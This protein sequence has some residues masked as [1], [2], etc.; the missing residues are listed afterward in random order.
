MAGSYT[1]QEIADA[2]HL[3]ALA[4]RSGAE[5][6][7]IDHE[8]ANN[9]TPERR[10]ELR[11]EADDILT[12][13]GRTLAETPLRSALVESLVADARLDANGECRRRIELRFEALQD[14]KRRLTEA[15]LRL[16]V[17]FAKRYR[18]STMS[19]L[20]RIQEGNLGL[21]KAVD[22]FQYRRGFKFSTYAV[23]WIRQS[24]SRAIAGSGGPSGYPCTR[25]N[26]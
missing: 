2:A 15:N 20:N 24:I 18:H 3:L 8:L 9:V 17:S 21:M 4:C 14:V 22:M 11:Q 13:V 5:L 16:V 1:V 7:H 26:Q 6:E 12:S 25:W 10:L 19:F 23:W